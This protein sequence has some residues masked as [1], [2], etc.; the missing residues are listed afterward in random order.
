MPGAAQRPEPFGRYLLLSRLA[1]GGMGE[2]YRALAPGLSGYERLVA[3][4]RMLPELGR[5]PQYVRLFAREARIAARLSHG[6]C[7]TIYDFGQVGDL[8]YACMEYVRGRSLAQ[9][10]RHCLRSGRTLGP[11]LALGAG[12][13]AFSALTLLGLAARRFRHR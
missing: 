3:I 12:L 1:V 13:A 2:V 11:A 9:I 4:K 5:D 8:V 7:V 6:N 10:I